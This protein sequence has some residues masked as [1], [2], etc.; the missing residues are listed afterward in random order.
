V[1]GKYAQYLPTL[2]IAQLTQFFAHRSFL[3][4][5]KTLPGNRR[6]RSEYRTE[7]GANS[8]HVL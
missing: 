4:G 8:H 2:G 1:G 3:L 7:K 5:R 6:L